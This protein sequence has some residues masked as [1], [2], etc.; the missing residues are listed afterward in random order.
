MDVALTIIV[1]FGGAIVGAA[2][3]FLGAVYI[4]RQRLHRTRVGIVKA[5]LG[6]LR[7]NASVAVSV[8]STREGNVAL[9]HDVEYSDQTWSA[10]NFELAQFL[11]DTP[12]RKLLSIYGM[13]PG[14][15]G[16]SAP[17]ALWPN[18]QLEI[19]ERWIKASGEA[20]KQ[21][22]QLPEAAKFRKDWRSLPS[23][24]EAATRTREAAKDVA[25]RQAPATS[26]EEVK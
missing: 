22:L 13:L 20:M 2:A 14:I 1:G 23:L 26:D 19:L 5:V 4:E 6:E 8:L 12:Y 21:L 24:E 15:R 10:A 9:G 16:L 3:G 11:G 7:G 17:A 25:G 18:Y